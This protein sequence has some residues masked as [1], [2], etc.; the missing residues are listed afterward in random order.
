QRCRRPWRGR[1]A[2]VDDPPAAAQPEI[3]DERPVGGDR[4]GSDAGRAEQQLIVA[5]LRDVAPELVRERPLREVAPLLGEA[6]PPEP[7]GETPE[8][9]VARDRADLAE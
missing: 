2:D 5:Q 8:A 6:R 1:V 3:V 9:G 4:L 7:P